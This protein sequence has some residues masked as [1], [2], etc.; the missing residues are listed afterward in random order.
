MNYRDFGG[1]ISV[2]HAS[3][4]CELLTGVDFLINL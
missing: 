4:I 3:Q 1:Q 2:S